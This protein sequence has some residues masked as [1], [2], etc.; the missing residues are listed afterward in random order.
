VRS[1]RAPGARFLVA[2]FFVAMLLT[3]GA[4]FTVY[5]RTLFSLP[6]WHALSHVPALNDA[7][8]FRLAVFSALAAAVIVAIWTASAHGVWTRRPVVVPCLAALAIAPAFW[9]GNNPHFNPIVPPRLAFFTDGTY[10]SC[11]DPG[12]TVAFIP[13]VGRGLLW[14]AES[15]FRFRLA[16]NG[17]QPFARSAPLNAFDS[18]PIVFDLVYGSAKPEMPMLLAFAGKHGVARFLTLPS[19]GWPTRA[20]L[21]TL[22][23]TR[24]TGG[25]LVT[26]RCGDP[27]FTSRNLSDYV[28]KYGNGQSP[29]SVAW[30]AGGAFF[31]LPEGTAPSG[32]RAGATHALFVESTGLTCSVPPGYKRHGFATQGVQPG[33][34]PYYTP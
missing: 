12:Q 19:E 2:A 30:C 5:G 23:R 11:L 21:A 16:A 33:I 3:L 18:D 25:A 32:D 17:L 7:L 10:R 29:P 24:L 4:T 22:G 20:D 14:Q 9:Q 31:L 28:A 26:P 8:P 15:D 27:P 34:Y 13:F 6:W 1:R